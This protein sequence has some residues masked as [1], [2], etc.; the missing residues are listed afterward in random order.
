MNEDRDKAVTMALG[1]V[2]AWIALLQAV[3]SDLLRCAAAIEPAPG[4]VDPEVDLTE[5]DRPT[6]VRAVLRNVA[7]GHV[8]AMIEDL[9]SLLRRDA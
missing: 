7:A 5:L 3:H 9:H 2:R 1:G 6:E 4:E 8:R